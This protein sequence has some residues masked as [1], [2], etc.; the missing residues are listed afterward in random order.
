MD[1]LLFIILQCLGKGRP[2]LLLKANDNRRGSDNEGG[3]NREAQDV[4]DILFNSNRSRHEIK[5][6]IKD[7]M[8][9]K[10]WTESLAKHILNALQDAIE[11]SRQMSSAMK[12]AYE[13]ARE[14]VEEF[15]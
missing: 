13:A 11:S 9:L 1:G 3:V 15:V 6:E 4:V 8:R 7:R 12:T 2:R 14:K 5:L 10:D